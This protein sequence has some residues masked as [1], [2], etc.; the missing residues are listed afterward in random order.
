MVYKAPK[1]HSVPGKGTSLVEWFLEKK[2]YAKNMP[3]ME[4]GLVNRLDF[5]TQGLVLFAGNHESYSKFLEE[6]NKG[7]II[8]T[9][10]ALVSSSDK[11]M[12]GF[13]PFKIDPDDISCPYTIKS[14]FRAFGS[15][16]KQVRPVDESADIKYLKKHKIYDK[17][18]STQ[19][20]KKH[21]ITD[22]LLKSN[23]EILSLHININQGFRHQIR[24]HLAWLGLPIL[25][26]LVYGGEK[27][28]L[29]MQTFASRT[30]GIQTKG[31]LALRASELMFS[32]PA[33]GEKL[34][35]KL[36]ELSIEE[37]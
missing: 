30:K 36:P 12:S 25:N 5:E 37:I 17:I 35:Y 14:F 11:R 18:Y 33:S 8:K 32:D 26:D 2:P 19:I 4:A 7:N 10:S 31:L 1:I 23:K 29:G 9:Y 22:R 15:G 27:T 28:A 6:Q 3:L 20:I 34:H 13:M 21:I 24:C 16:R